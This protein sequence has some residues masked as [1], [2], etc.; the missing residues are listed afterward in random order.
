MIQVYKILN[1][2]DIVE[3]DKLFTRAQY[4]ANRGH[5]FKLHKK[6]SRLNVR[7]NTFSNRFFNTSNDLPDKVVNA[8]SVNSFKSRLNKHWHGHPSKFEPA[9]YQTGH[10]AREYSQNCQE[11]PFIS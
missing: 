3:K 11:A 1:D 8:P 7:A 6:R 9:C 10:P 5:F 2:I 4:T